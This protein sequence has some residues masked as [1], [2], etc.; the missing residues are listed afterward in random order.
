MTQ[1][2]I[3]QKITEI[4]SADRNSISAKAKEMFWRY[5]LRSGVTRTNHP[6]WCEAVDDLPKTNKI[7]LLNI[8]TAEI[9]FDL[10]R[11]AALELFPDMYSHM[12]VPH[13]KPI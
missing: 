5:A 13:G 12:E 10:V 4:L 8:I 7:N 11:R 2:E 9:T 3:A 1:S 6:R